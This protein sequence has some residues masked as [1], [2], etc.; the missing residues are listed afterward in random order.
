MAGKY[1]GKLR[2]HLA[3]LLF[4]TASLKELLL[5]GLNAPRFR[6]VTGAKL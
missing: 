4:R 3:R 5:P 1:Q 2:H 6:V